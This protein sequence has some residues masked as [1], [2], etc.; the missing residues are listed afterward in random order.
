MADTGWVSAGAGASVVIGGTAWTNPGN[1]TASDD[2]YATV[3]LGFLSFSNALRGEA[4]GLAVPAG[5]TID[6]IEVRFE[7]GASAAGSYSINA[8]N[9]G[10]DSSTLATAKAAFN[11]AN[12]LEAYH[13][14]GGA[15]D[16]WGLTWTPA[17]VNASTFLAQ[18][19][20]TN[21]AL[22]TRTF[23][24]DS[25]EVKVHYTPAPQNARLFIIS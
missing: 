5:A 3:T 19:Y 12:A 8:A 17:E 25:V 4:F 14:F 24:A 7:V 10:K 22:G 9:I 11:P 20:V 21:A 2:T 16:L 13:T 18:F 23:N 15:S 1:I 6:G